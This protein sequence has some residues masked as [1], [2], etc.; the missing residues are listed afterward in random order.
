MGSRKWE[1][2]EGN[3]EKV[4]GRGKWEVGIGKMGMGRSE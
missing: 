3:W 1:V 4:V 2:G